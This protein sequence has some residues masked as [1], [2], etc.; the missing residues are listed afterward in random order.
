MTKGHPYHPKHC[1]CQVPKEDLMCLNTLSV[2][3]DGRVYDCDFNQALGMQMRNGRPFSIFDIKLNE[4]ENLEI[5]TGNHCFGCTAGAG[6]SC[7]GALQ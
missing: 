2:G 7:Q 3:W 5:L 6:S 4:I 1:F